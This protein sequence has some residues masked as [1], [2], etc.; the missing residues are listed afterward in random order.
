MINKYNRDLVI[1]ALGTP[2][3]KKQAQRKVLTLKLEDTIIP[4]FTMTNADSI[5]AIDRDALG[6]PIRIARDEDGTPKINKTTGKLR[7]IMA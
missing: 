5:T 2:A 3:A 6:A 1:S 7:E 4:F